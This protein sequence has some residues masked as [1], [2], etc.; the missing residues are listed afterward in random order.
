M[1]KLQAISSIEL[2]VQIVSFKIQFQI[3]RLIF[4]LKKN[5][6]LSEDKP[7]K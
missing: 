6:D 4:I 5:V 1:I 2:I 3:E 7:R